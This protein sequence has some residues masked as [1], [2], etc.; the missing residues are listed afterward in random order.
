MVWLDVA[1]LLEA[2]R[3]VVKKRSSREKSVDGVLGLGYSDLHFMQ[4]FQHKF[5]L[6]TY[7]LGIRISFV[8]T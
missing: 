5:C 6:T 8:S 7:F 2:V 3:S 4:A 1:L